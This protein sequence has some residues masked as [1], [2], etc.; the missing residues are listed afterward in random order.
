MRTENSYLDLIFRLPK[1]K[2]IKNERWLNKGELI[3]NTLI[4][5]K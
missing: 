2:K 1:K 3:M 4:D 5:C